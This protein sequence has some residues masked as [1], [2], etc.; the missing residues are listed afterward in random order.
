MRLH[1]SHILAATA[2]C[3]MSA[4]A[5]AQDRAPDTTATAPADAAQST[6]ASAPPAGEATPRR[7]SLMGMVMGA[8]IDSAEQSARRQ[9]EAAGRAAASEVAAAPDPASA[10]LRAQTIREQIAVQDDDPR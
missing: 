10:R 1:L 7:K 6:S 3:L 5:S 9:R 8:L 2:L 4:Q